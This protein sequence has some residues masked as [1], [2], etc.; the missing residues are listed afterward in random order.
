MVITPE[1]FVRFSAGEMTLAEL[2]GLRPIQG[3]VARRVGRPPLGPPQIGA[4]RCPVWRI[5]YR[6]AA[7]LPDAT[8]IRSPKPIKAHQGDAQ[9][10][11]RA[12]SV[13][14]TWRR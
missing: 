2:Q 1:T 10:S 9:R 12:I 5:V 4:F 3:E 6:L 8:M 13:R 14:R 7:R 11:I